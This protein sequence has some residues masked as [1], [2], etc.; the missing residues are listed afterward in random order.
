[1]ENPLEE[2]T[3]ILAEAP[4]LIHELEERFQEEHDIVLTLDDDARTMLAEM[5]EEQNK[6]PADLG[7]ELFRDYVHGL[8]LVQ[9]RELKITAEAIRN[10]GEYL[11]TLIKKFYEKTAAKT[12]GS[13][14]QHGI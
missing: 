11:D 5:A 13:G 8:K 1:V 7:M 2:L 14:K 6:S 12:E 3:R 4:P 10:P 9:T